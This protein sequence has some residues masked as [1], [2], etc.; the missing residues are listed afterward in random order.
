VSN[1]VNWL[2]V[3]AGIICVIIEL[4]LGALTGFDLALLGASLAVGGVIGLLIGPAKI[5]LLAAGALAFLYLAVFRSWLKRK[6]T[7][8]DQASNVDAVVGKTGVVT[9][10]IAVR[11]P[12]M[13]KVGAEIW[14]AELAGGD[15][16]AKDAGAVVVVQSVEGVTLRV[17]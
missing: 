11:E 4:A 1:W 12:G 13:V 10:R 7:V 2:L 17:R 8:K 15:E 9:K 16:A 6:L 5:G 3:I 14:R